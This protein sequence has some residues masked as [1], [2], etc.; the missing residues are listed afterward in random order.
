MVYAEMMIIL[1][2]L[3][4]LFVVNFDGVM[5]SQKESKEPPEPTYKIQEFQTTDSFISGHDGQW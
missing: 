4:L 3:V 1:A 2:N 5:R